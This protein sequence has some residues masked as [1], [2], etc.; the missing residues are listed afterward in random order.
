M[1]V[2]SWPSDKP[3]IYSYSSA[4]EAEKSS[5]TLVPY[6]TA[7]IKEATGRLPSIIAHSMGARLYNDSIDTMVYKGGLSQGKAPS[8]ILA[9]PD[10]DGDLFLK[11][12]NLFSAMNHLTTVYCGDDNALRLSG[13]D[14]WDRR[15]GYCINSE[16]K[17]SGP[18]ALVRVIG[19]FK[20]TWHHSYFLSSPEMIYD[21]NN[22]LSKGEHAE[23]KKGEIV[24][25][26][27]RDLELH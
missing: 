12:F 2:V 7:M 11:Q 15:L 21:M 25:I 3:G 22:V 14:H 20:D 16:K 10:V 24:Q 4:E 8:T 23:D 5:L 26:P 17:T 19:R 9:A 27:P 6:S 13:I 18:E 1:I